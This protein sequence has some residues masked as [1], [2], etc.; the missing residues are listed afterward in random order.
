MTHGMCGDVVLVKD[1]RGGVERVVGADDA[2]VQKRRS[3][4]VWLRVRSNGVGEHDLS[5][6]VA[7]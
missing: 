7:P 4:Q 2:D 3:S 5:A 6:V 1:A